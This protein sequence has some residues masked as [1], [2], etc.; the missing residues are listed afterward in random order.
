MRQLLDARVPIDDLLG[1]FQDVQGYKMKLIL[2]DGIV[3]RT[4][5]PPQLALVHEQG[6]FPA[7]AGV[8]LNQSL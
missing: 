2:T 8:L 4:S 7:L 5:N 6:L 3:C 1:V